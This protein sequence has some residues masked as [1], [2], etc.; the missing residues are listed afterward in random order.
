MKHRFSRR[1]ILKKGLLVSAVAP[2]LGLLEH[3][4]AYAENMLLDSADPAGKA[5]GYVA[6]SANAQQTCANCAQYKGVAGSSKGACAI[7]PGKDVVA[8]GYC[9]AWLKKPA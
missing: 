9:K 7:F 5:L 3:S 6:A 8:A 4:P 1:E 2:M